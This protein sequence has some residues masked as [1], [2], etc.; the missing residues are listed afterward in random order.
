MGHA[1]N[2]NDA[3]K[4][5]AVLGSKIKHFLERG[6]LVLYKTR[7]EHITDVTHSVYCSECHVR[8]GALLEQCLNLVKKEHGPRVGS[9]DTTVAVGPLHYLFEAFVTPAG[10]VWQASITDRGDVCYKEY[11][12]RLG[13]FQYTTQFNKEG[14]LIYV[15]KVSVP[16]N[17][18]A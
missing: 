17:K 1:R 3:N 14:L 5:N 6:A 9:L 2:N 15:S 16:A 11:R 7:L 12:L 4:A 10:V 18:L 13:E 8:I